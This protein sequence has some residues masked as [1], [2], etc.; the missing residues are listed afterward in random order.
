MDSPANLSF[1]DFS[2]CLVVRL[3][4]RSVFDDQGVTVRTIAE[5]V[6]ARSP[7]A[8]LVDFRKVPGSISFMDRF[9]AAEFAGKHLTG[10][11]LAV[12][13][14]EEQTDES[15]IGQLVAQNRG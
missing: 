15:R 12:L 10:L 4:S 11:A 8:M 7:K 2:G 14:R 1:E 5:T 6:R 13:A 9:H 3:V